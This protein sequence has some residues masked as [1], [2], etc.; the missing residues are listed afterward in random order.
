VGQGALG[1]DDARPHGIAADPE[2]AE[3]DGR[4]ASQC[5]K[6]RLGRGVDSGSG[7]RVLRGDRGDVDY[8]P[9]LATTTAAGHDR[10]QALH[11]EQRAEHVDGQHAAG[12]V[13]RGL[14]ERRVPP[15]RG[16]VDQRIAVPEPGGQVV[17]GGLVGDVDGARGRPDLIGHLGHFGLVCV[18]GPHREAVRDQA[19]GDRPAKTSRRARHDRRRHES[20]RS[21]GRLPAAPGGRQFTF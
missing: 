21:R 10:D 5:L 12:L 16:V 15:D 7:R 8:R 2:R 14:R 20:S 4:D 17:D 18:E 6:R 19:L 1:R 11:E 3:L 9:T 13:D